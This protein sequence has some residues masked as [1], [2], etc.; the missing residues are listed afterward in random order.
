VTKDPAK[1]AWPFVVIPSQQASVKI[2]I[3]PSSS[4]CTSL[5]TLLLQQPFEEIEEK[6]VFGI[7]MLFVAL[8]KA[9]QD[10]EASPSRSSKHLGFSELH[11]PS[12]SLRLLRT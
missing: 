5:G 7:Q 4:A 1:P 2:T 12:Q 8:R 3:S 6:D 10:L 11:P 9:A